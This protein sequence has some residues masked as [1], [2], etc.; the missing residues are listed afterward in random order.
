MV[1]FIACHY[2]LSLPTIRLHFPGIAILLHSYLQQE[3]YICNSNREQKFISADQINVTGSLVQQWWRTW[4]TNAAIGFSALPLPAYFL[5]SI[6]T[7]QFTTVPIQ[8]HLPL[9]HTIVLLQPVMSVLQLS[10][11]GRAGWMAVLD[12][13]LILQRPRFL[14]L[15]SPPKVTACTP[16]VAKSSVFDSLFKKALFTCSNLPYILSLVNSR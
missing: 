8:L 15:L 13:S 12:L 4:S 7:Q 16:A 9:V 1:L 3:D 6:G 2:H 10:S 5:S 11:F 14:T